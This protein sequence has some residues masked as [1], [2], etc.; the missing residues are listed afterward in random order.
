MLRINRFPQRFRLIIALASYVAGLGAGTYWL[1]DGSRLSL[2]G[3][4]LLLGCA[5]L[6][7][8]YATGVVLLACSMALLGFWWGE[9]SLQIMLLTEPL[10]YEGQAIVTSVRFKDPP[11]Q[12]IVLQ[13]LEGSK[14]GYKTRA[15]AY[16]WGAGVGSVL[17][18]AG[19]I[20]P[21]TYR[22]DF[23]S[24]IIGTINL[25][26]KEKIGE[27]SWLFH[28]R[29]RI[30]KSITDTIPEPYASLANGLI[31]GVN[32]AFDAGFQ[33]DLQRTGTTHV[34]AV[35]G[36][37]ITIVAMLLKGIG[38]WWHRRAGLGLAL[39]GIG[40]Y[41]LLA[42]GNP[43]LLRGAAVGMLSLFASYAGRPV[44]RLPLI[45]LTVVILSIITPMGMLYS[46][47][48]Q[49]SFGAFV[50]ILFVNPLVS[51]YGERLGMIGGSLLETISASLMVE[52]L[53]LLRFGTLSLIGPFVNIAVL[54]ITP[55]AMG[56]SVLQAVVSLISV[57]LGHVIAWASYPTLWAIV[58]P[59]TWSSTLP[60]ALYQTENFTVVYSVI[61]YAIILS[62]LALLQW[63]AF[64]EEARVIAGE[65]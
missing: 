41:V 6:V 47:S 19:D 49:L 53:I 34:V 48:W 65:E 32:D 51:P 24:G 62:G 16:D 26:K 13:L 27:P 20:K 35:S 63:W 36:Y 58:T 15:S 28:M 56:M 54:S 64:K 45:L 43:S 57:P 59:I 33:E 5:C 10:H 1:L 55:L 52:P 30:Q 44:H 11:E 25:D 23:G 21:S 14:R 12:R 42:G 8:P 46:M 22:T 9:Q 38:Q 2:I 50:G 31:T 4:F 18:I 29:Q 7:R 17:Q 40:A 39:C 3:M 60:F 37:N 61:A